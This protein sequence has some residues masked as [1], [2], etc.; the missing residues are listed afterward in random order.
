MK[1]T[2]R[3]KSKMNDQNAYLSIFLSSYL[4]SYLQTYMYVEKCPFPTIANGK[5]TRDPHC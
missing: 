3:K 4:S 5:N 2:Y 1:V